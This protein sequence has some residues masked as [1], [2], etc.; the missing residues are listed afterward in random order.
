[1]ICFISWLLCGCGD[2]QPEPITGPKA[3]PALYDSERPVVTICALR[4]HSIEVALQ[5]LE[6]SSFEEENGFEVRAT[7]LEFEPM[8]QA[9][10]LNF[11]HEP[12][13]YDIVSIDQ[14]S[15]GQYVTRGWVIALDEF[16]RTA[17][18]PSLELDDIIPSLLGPCGQWK[19]QTY[20][21]PLGSYGALLAY[22]SDLFKQA[23]VTP[24]TTFDEFL[25][26]A[27]KMNR[28]P[29][30]Y[31]TALFAHSG[32]YLTADA[33]PFL[34]SWGSG[35]I[36]GCDVNLPDHPAY[37]AAWDSPGGIAALEFY[38]TIYRTGLTPPDTLTFDHARYIRAFQNGR[39]AM[40]L[41]PAEGFGEPMNDPTASRVAGEID[42]TTLPRRRRA[43]GIL[44]PT[45]PGLGAHS[46]AISSNSPHPRE[47]YKVLQFL[48]G[49]TIGRDYILRGG[50]PARIS[51]FTAEALDR[52]P[53]LAAIREGISTGRCRPNIPEYP[54]VSEIFFTALHSA[55]LHDAPI[56][57][58]MRAAAVKANQ[59]V[60]LPAYPER[61]T[62]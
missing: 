44:E 56:A 52:F 21:V 17:S 27:R 13:R 4:D 31:G 45:R 42:Y 32:E 2:P 40:G 36:T 58:V 29:E 61:S 9:H 20:A 3:R 35:L 54:E 22:R 37:R 7:L 10:K 41:M 19:G 15:L 33:A 55:L 49:K 30:I 60:L 51:H 48:T 8:T 18:L 25:L 24:P 6:E 39:V 50:R 57:E 1:M 59:E 26:T 53:Y 23:N 47:A 14:P 34:W 28:P 38:A 16:S 11:N 43:D 46:L 5:L 62:L 12:C